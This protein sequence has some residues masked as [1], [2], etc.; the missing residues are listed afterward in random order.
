VAAPPP[1]APAAAQAAPAS[2]DQRIVPGDRI[3]PVRLEERL[4]DVFRTFGRDVSE[5]P[6]TWAGTTYYEWRSAAL[7]VIADDISGH[8]LSI[9]VCACA[10]NP[11]AGHA[12]AEGIGLGASEDQVVA[13]L[14]APSRRAEDARART[15]HYVR[16]GISFILPLTGPQAG[17]VVSIRVAWP[18][19]APGD[20]TA[21]E[22]QRISGITLGMSAEAALAALGGGYLQQRTAER[23]RYHWPQSGLVLDVADGKVE[24]VLVLAEQM[25]EQA[26]IRY[27]TPDGLGFNSAAQEVAGAYGAPAERRPQGAW[28]LWLYPSRGIGFGVSVQGRPGVV[29]GIFV[30][31]RRESA[32]R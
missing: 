10:S 32:P 31:T 30:F 2:D 24:Q 9:S 14:G 12:T 1:A 27:A 5:G 22:N 4:P 25:L 3:G 7:A 26:G 8:L 13:A 6:G 29:V 16:Q 15:I 18:V 28:E 20:T 19:R 21:V 11:W 17:R 23:S